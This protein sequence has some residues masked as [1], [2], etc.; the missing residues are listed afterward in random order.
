M[1]EV[2]RKVG[3]SST[4]PMPLLVAHAQYSTDKGS[5]G[6]KDPGIVVEIAR[7]V[8]GIQALLPL[9]VCHLDQEENVL[10]HHFCVARD[11]R[12]PPQVGTG[13]ED[14]RRVAE[15]RERESS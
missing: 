14:D 13:T 1:K 5:I 10:C 15:P 6:R 8:W 3:F 4:V 11:A 12:R 2:S 9:P 7:R